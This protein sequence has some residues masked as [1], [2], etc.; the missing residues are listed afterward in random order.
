M[1]AIEKDIPAPTTSRVRSRGDFALT[2]DALQVGESFVAPGRQPK[3]VYASISQKKFPG[4]KF[5]VAPEAAV[6]DSEG[7]QTRAQG[8]RVW[9]T[10]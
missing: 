8:V 2:V 1:F 9:R 6:V 5:R 4:K 7:V 10:E 3:G